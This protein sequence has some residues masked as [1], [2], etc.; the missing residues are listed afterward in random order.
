MNKDINPWSQNLLRP[1]PT[2][3]E[4][5]ILKQLNEIHKV[6]SPSLK[7]IYQPKRLT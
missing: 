4:Y 7:L 1:S 6:T 3:K 2:L 5:K